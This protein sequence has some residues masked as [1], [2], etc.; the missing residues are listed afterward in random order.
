MNT[1]SAGVGLRERKKQQTR[2]ALHR[3][4]IQLFAE[5]GPESVTVNDIC[6]AADVSPR[7]FFNYF[8]S[9]D[10]AVLDWT[11]Q[12]A[13]GSLTERIIARPP[14][15]DPLEAV[16]QAINTGIRNLQHRPTWREY[17]QMV[18]QNPRLVPMAYADSRHTLTSM[19]E[20]IAHRTG[21]PAD[22]LY[23][24]AAAGAAH[25][26]TRTA[27]AHWNPDDS[28]SDLLTIMN[29][30]FDMLVAGFPPPGT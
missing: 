29:T 18:R 9:K 5:R 15:E 25:A 20:G 7:T 26:A 30:A 22:D 3:A 12:Q 2:E 10:D 28:T 23:P 6:A 16:R 24:Q 8:D 27:L 14:E 17:Q 19:I 21:L 1:A 11:E 4:A 13:G